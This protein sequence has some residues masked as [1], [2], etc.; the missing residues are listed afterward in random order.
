[1]SHNGRLPAVEVT[2]SDSPHSRR[3]WSDAEVEHLK[4]EVARWRQDPYYILVMPQTVHFGEPITDEDDLRERV[5]EYAETWGTAVVLRTDHGSY[6][7]D[8]D[9]THYMTDTGWVQHLRKNEITVKAAMA[10]YREERDAEA[11]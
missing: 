6:I 7:L 2:H 8:E 1:M 5:R 3:K 9:V 10:A 4:E 11:T